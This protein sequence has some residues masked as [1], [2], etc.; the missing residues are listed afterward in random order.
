ML[1]PKQMEQDTNRLFPE[2]WSI[3]EKSAVLLGGRCETCSVRLFPRPTYCPKC[4]SEKIETITLPSE[5]VLY[6]F[7]V[8]RL[9]STQLKA[10]YAIG[11][12][13]LEDGPRVL[14]HLLGWE[15]GLLKPDMRV[16]LNYGPLPSRVSSESVLTYKF[17]AYPGGGLE[18]TS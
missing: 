17:E 4:L 10:P 6:A 1:N 12:V 11:Y 3:H 18:V 15:E 7:S 8:V 16:R 13:D 2:D 5:G 9:D 14:A